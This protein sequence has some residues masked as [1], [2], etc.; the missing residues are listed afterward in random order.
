MSAW[1]GKTRGCEQASGS[2]SPHKGA[3]Q[4]MVLFQGIPPQPIVR[5]RIVDMKEAVH[6]ARTFADSKQRGLREAT[7]T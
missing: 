5:L 7:S 2:D 3:Q 6:S 4:P 1:L